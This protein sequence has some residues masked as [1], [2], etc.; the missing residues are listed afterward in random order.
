[1]WE[2]PTSWRTISSRKPVIMWESLAISKALVLH[3]ILTARD[4]SR[5]I[6]LGPGVIRGAADADLTLMQSFVRI[7]TML[8]SA[9]IGH[10]RYYDE[11]EDER[12]KRRKRRKRRPVRI[13]P[14]VRYRHLRTPHADV[15]RTIEM[16]SWTTTCTPTIVLL[17]FS[18]GSSARPSR[19]TRRGSASRRTKPTNQTSHT[20][21]T[22][23][24]WEG[25]GNFFT[26]SL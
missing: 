21:R 4:S 18:C 26:G 17:P 9:A 19:V 14:G 10:K 11:K 8:L 25:T 7:S 16:R 5:V 13:Q 23:I 1:M 24:R 3:D 20:G 15:W 2:K 6:T 12:R 22:R